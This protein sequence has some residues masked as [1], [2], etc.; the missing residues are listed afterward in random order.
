MAT[1]TKK[2]KSKEKMIPLPHRCERCKE[3]FTKKSDYEFHTMKHIGADNYHMISFIGAEI[4]LGNILSIM[5]Y[6]EIGI[7]EALDIYYNDVDKI[8]ERII[9]NKPR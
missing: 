7:E 4:R 5:Q 9:G 2:T 1:I 6:K 3:E 8:N